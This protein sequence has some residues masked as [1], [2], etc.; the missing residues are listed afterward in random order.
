MGHGGEVFIFDMGEPV[1]IADLAL[2]MIK[3]AGLVP[4]KDI[5]IEYSGLRPGEKLYEE[6]LNK[7]EEVIP[8]HHK[9]I[10]ISR[11]NKPALRTIIENVDYLIDIAGKNKNMSIVKQ[12][13]VIVHEYKSNNSVYE[14]LDYAE[15]STESP[16]TDF[17]ESELNPVF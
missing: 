16:I 14:K 4:G 11:V 8:T 3:L 10:M 6:L 12:M 17:K 5:N 13:K 9:K 7:A 15:V 1:K 2:K